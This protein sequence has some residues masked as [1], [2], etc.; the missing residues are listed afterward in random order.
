MEGIY[1]L[2]GFLLWVWGIVIGWRA[3]EVHAKQQVEK[4]LEE[5]TAEPESKN[6]LVKI[7]IEKSNSQFFVYDLYTNE[8]MAQGSTRSQVE[9]ALAKRYPG[10]HFA[11]TPENLSE[12]GF[13]S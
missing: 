12:I 2:I 13:T 11:A 7:K 6:D 5:T 4:F 10:K 3:R 8:F 9:N 1:I